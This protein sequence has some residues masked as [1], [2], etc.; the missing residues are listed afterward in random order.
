MRFLR[1]EF[2]L[3][4]KLVYGL[5]YLAKIYLLGQ[6]EIFW[7]KLLWDL[8]YFFNSVISLMAN[9]QTRKQAKKIP[10][11][12]EDLSPKLPIIYT[13]DRNRQL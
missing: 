11:R 4:M 10:E 13:T 12:R 2:F 1:R 7:G 6:G 5:C 9:K 8:F 3:L